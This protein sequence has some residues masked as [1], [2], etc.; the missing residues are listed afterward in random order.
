MINTS[1]TFAGDIVGFISRSMVKGLGLTT[2]ELMLART[3]AIKYAGK[4]DKPARLLELMVRYGMDFL[5]VTPFESR[6]NQ[7]PSHYQSQLLESSSFNRTTLH[8]HPRGRVFE[9][10]RRLLTAKNQLGSQSRV[11]RLTSAHQQ[12]KRYC[13]AEASPMP[14]GPLPPEPLWKAELWVQRLP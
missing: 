13:S 8:R 11:S 4:H 10:F 14:G 12:Q 9:R 2:A 6:Q 1:P 7:G 5:T 3:S